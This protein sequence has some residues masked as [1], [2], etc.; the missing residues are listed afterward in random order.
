[1]ETG[2][3]V[4]LGPGSGQCKQIPGLWSGK[5]GVRA[6]GGACGQE[7]EKRGSGGNCVLMYL[8]G[9]WGIKAPLPPLQLRVSF[10]GEFTKRTDK[11]AGMRVWRGRT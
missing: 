10:W 3:L 9:S 11:G 5:L 8:E 1:M 4:S 7:A 6:W 2:T